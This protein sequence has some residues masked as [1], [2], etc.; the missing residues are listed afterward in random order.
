MVQK[1]KIMEV[2]DQ[3]F[4]TYDKPWLPVRFPSVRVFEVTGENIEIRTGMVVEFK[5]DMS[6]NSALSKSIKA[7]LHEIK[8]GAAVFTP[9]GAGTHVIGII[10][11]DTLNVETA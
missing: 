3:S 7:A 1:T 6:Y 5:I 8:Q 4:K 11:L 10:N 2:A 9:I